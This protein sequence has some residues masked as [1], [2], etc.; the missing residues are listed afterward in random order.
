VCMRKSGHA[1]REIRVLLVGLAGQHVS[2]LQA[3]PG[4]R[5]P[6]VIRAESCVEGW[7]RLHESAFDVLIVDEAADGGGWRDLIAEIGA[8]GLALPVV[9]ASAKADERL[10]VD[11]LW[12][13]AYDVIE[14]PF[15]A[16]E[17]SRI[18]LAAAQQ[19]G[20]SASDARRRCLRAG[21]LGRQA[22]LARS[23]AAARLPA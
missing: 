4:G 7:K 18:L 13:G 1:R 17:T 20:H 9:L 23:P 16:A 6:R 3:I 22:A 12:A 21:S 14:I 19:R 15:H 2:E 11:A 10:W 5:G 8:M